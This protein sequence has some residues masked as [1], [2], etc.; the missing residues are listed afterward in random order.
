MSII[1]SPAPPVY[2]RPQ[3]LT[4]IAEEG[5]ADQEVPED[6]AAFRAQQ[7]A[8]L[9]PVLT[10]SESE[11]RHAWLQVDAEIRKL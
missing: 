3:T 1:R 10:Q 7:A 8:N 4:P 9:G 5:P 11:R 2:L 6:D